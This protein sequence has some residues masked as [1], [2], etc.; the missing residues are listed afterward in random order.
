MANILIFEWTCGGGLEHHQAFGSGI[1][2][3]GAARF[4]DLQCEG[5]GM[6]TALVSDFA[7]AGHRVTTTISRR[8]LAASSMGGQAVPVDS[9]ASLGQILRHGSDQSDHIV[10]IAPESGGVL[11]D[12]LHWF[13]AFGNKLL[14]PT[15]KLVEI[16]SS[17][18][19]T[20]QWLAARD[21]PAPRGTRIASSDMAQLRSSR[22][23]QSREFGGSDWIVKPDD[24]AGGESL[25][26]WGSD[27][28]AP[29]LDQHVQWR[30]ERLMDGL[31]VS[32]LAL[33]GPGE[34]VVLPP[35]QQIL[36]CGQF[37]T[38]LGGRFPLPNK[39]AE[40]ARKLAQSAIQT[41]A[42]LKG[43]VGVDMVVSADG[44]G[45]CV[46]EINPRLTSSYQLL[47][48]RTTANLADTMLRVAAGARVSIEFSNEPAERF[49]AAAGDLTIDGTRLG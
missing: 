3:G 40:Q 21:V 26:R 45:D 25:A 24:G 7:V 11:A 46:I 18:H 48:D 15:P 4:H 29:T 1:P 31:P 39:L 13:K 5:I 9:A 10:V 33:C 12:C 41:M 23:N 34:N 20:C 27:S 37:G 49:V 35:C 32:A 6:L 2:P 47:R 38:Y 42:G 14:A 19:R 44:I 22:S 16:C 30:V 17:K 43:F 36:S 8:L 28:D